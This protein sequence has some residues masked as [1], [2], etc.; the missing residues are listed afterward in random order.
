MNDKNCT[1]TYFLENHNCYLA[2]LAMLMRLFNEFSNTVMDVCE[3]YAYY[4]TCMSCWKAINLQNRPLLARR[5]GA[6]RPR[7]ASIG[8]FI[9]VQEE[10]NSMICHSCLIAQKKWDVSIQRRGGTHI[11]FPVSFPFMFHHFLRQWRRIANQ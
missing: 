7:R 5:V 3:G 1:F 2:S 11:C 6:T 4:C 9:Q 8:W 10:M